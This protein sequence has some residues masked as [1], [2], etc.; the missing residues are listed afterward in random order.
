MNN[1]LQLLKTKR[2]TPLFITQ[3]LG[4]FNDNLYKNALIILLTFQSAQWSELKP[5]LLANLAAGIFILPFFLFSATA[6]QL[7]DKYDKA[8]LA[9]LT[10]ILEIIIML[11]AVAGFVWH[12]FNLLLVAL[13]LL[14]LQSTLF[15]PIKYAILPQHLTNSELLGGNGVIEAGTFIAILL[16][17]IGGS[18]L[19]GNLE[20]QLWLGLVAVLIAIC[21]YLSSRH[22]PSAPAINNTI[23]LDLN[24][25]RQTNQCIKF[26]KQE[27]SVFLSILGISW[28]WLYGSVL[29]TQLPFFSK[30]ILGGSE[31]ASTLLLAVFTLGIGLGSALCERMS[32]QQVEIGL[33]PF[34][35]IGLT[36]FGLDIFLA[37][38]ASTS[39]S[40]LSLA[41]VLQQ[42]LTWRICFDLFMLGIF[43]GFYI[44]PLYALVQLRSK[45]QERARIIAANN[46]L[47]AL[48][49]VIGAIA[50]A[51]LLKLGLTIPQLFMLAALC[52]ALVAIYIYSLVPEFF[53]RFMAWL[54]IKLVYRLDC[55]GRQHIPEQ[56]A[57]LLVCNHVS[58]ADAVIL[59][60][61]SPRPIRFVMDHRIFKTPVL[62]FIFR[63]SKAIPIAP[64]KE[65]QQLMQQA[66]IDIDEALANGELVAIFPEG[67]ITRDGEL[68]QFRPGVT[69]ILDT[70]PTPVIP[71]ALSGLWGSFFSRIDG[72]AMTR[73]LRRGAFSRISLQIGAPISAEQATPEHLQ[74]IVKQLRGERL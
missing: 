24:F 57:A 12:S 39:E 58:F 70:R 13:F 49:M 36:L 43:G 67:A 73:P 1:Q 8:W 64:A 71:M 66:F 3:F 65:N 48:F 14:G 72:K 6:G 34:G 63:H 23:K 2:F 7:A 54:L 60:G 53:I 11:V 44:V 62:G 56:G 21:G 29:L 61:A 16:G 55:S 41:L 20:N 30:N 4:A 40:A 22:I 47:N 32:N 52:N 59:M 18:L 10:K 25:I 37:A 15:G 46:V 9:R 19:A 42:P 27:R 69:R 33:V 5:E 35:S 74:H 45:A 50:A 68:Q 26:A 38:P 51:I 31:S 28:F 17:T